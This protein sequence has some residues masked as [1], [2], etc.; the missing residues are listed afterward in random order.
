M[1]CPDERSLLLSWSASVVGVFACLDGMRSA[2][3]FLAR[4]FPWDTTATET[5]IL[6]VPSRVRVLG[7]VVSHYYV[8]ALRA[9]YLF[10]GHRG[11]NSLVANKCAGKGV[12]GYHW[13]KDSS[14]SV[15]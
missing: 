12:R 13:G 15:G 5:D 6:D 7:R 14:G 9:Q 11:H 10:V 2:V 8:P 3:G 4:A 1:V